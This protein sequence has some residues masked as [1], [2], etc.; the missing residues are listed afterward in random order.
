VRKR[1]LEKVDRAEPGGL[2]AVRGKVGAGEN[3]R[4]G[5]GMAGAQIVEELLAEVGDGIDIEHEEIRL[6]AQDEVLRAFQGRRD[7]DLARRRGFVEGSADFFGQIEIR[8]EH[9]DA[10]GRC[11]GIGGL[12]RRHFVYDGNWRA[13]SASLG[14]RDTP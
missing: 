5:I 8:L 3:D 14:S 6:C 2:F 12:G 7:V 13:V 1:F 10:P 11:G 9:E 4:A